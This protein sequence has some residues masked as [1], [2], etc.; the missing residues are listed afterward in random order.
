MRTVEELETE[1][2][3]VKAGLATLEKRRSELAREL[4][5][6]K[7]REFI[8]VNGVQLKDV[9]PN[10]GP[11]IPWHGDAYQFGAWLREQNCSKR[12]AVWNGML[13]F[14]D[15]LAMGRL[16]PTDGRAEDIPGWKE[17]A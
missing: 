9:Q 4:S 14:T 11:G 1:I 2:D 17:G 6:V 3:R 7:S 13:V 10:Q 8:R 16:R 15:E 5:Q 12:F